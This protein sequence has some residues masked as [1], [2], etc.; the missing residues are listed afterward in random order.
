M[1]I[2]ALNYITVN[3]MLIK[4]CVPYI[5]WSEKGKKGALSVYVSRCSSSKTIWSQ[6]WSVFFFFFSVSLLSLLLCVLFPLPLSEGLYHC[7]TAI[8]E[9]NRKD[10]WQMFGERCFQIH[11][12][13]CLLELV[14]VCRLVPPQSSKERFVQ[15]SFEARCFSIEFVY[16]T[17]E[18][19]EKKYVNMRESEDATWLQSIKTTKDTPVKTIATDYKDWCGCY[20]DYSTLQYLYRLHNSPCPTFTVVIRLYVRYF[21]LY[22]R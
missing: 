17:A 13:A 18:T 21:M 12:F 22:C 8:T 1:Y 2:W 10:T 9:N 7:C 6:A 5:T 15:D 4:R 3:R 20:N 11:L 19:P 16:C 14:F